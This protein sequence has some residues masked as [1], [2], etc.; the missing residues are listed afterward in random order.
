MF[1]DAGFTTETVYARCSVGSVA[2]T[3]FAQDK[4]SLRERVIE[5]HFRRFVENGQGSLHGKRINPLA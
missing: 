4:E 3:G 1:P 2:K 5:F